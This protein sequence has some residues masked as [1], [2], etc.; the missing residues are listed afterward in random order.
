[1]QCLCLTAGAV[2]HRCADAAAI[3]AVVCSSCSVP[4]YPVGKNSPVHGCIP[5]G[6]RTLSFVNGNPA[7][8]TVQI[9]LIHFLYILFLIV[10]HRNNLLSC[11]EKRLPCRQAGADSFFSKY[12]LVQPGYIDVF[13][14]LYTYDS[15]VRNAVFEF[16]Q[17][18]MAP[19][20]PRASIILRPEISQTY[21]CRNESAAA[22][23]APPA[24]SSPETLRWQYTGQGSE[25]AY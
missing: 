10:C 5:P 14:Y 15:P 16:M 8:N 4:F 21:T 17:Y 13:L 24:Q 18:S 11:D 9:F 2:C 23:E 25:S 22:P 6:V 20:H 19:P 7:G 1:M 12:S 3:L